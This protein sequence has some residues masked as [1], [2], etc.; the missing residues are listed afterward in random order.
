M[1]TV[2]SQDEV[3]VYRRLHHQ[4]FGFSEDELALRFTRCHRG[5]LL[6][7]DEW[8]RWPRWDETRW[9]PD[10]TREVFDLAR[11]VCRDAAKAAPKY[12]K[13]IRSARTVAAIVKLASADRVHARVTEDFDSDPWLLN[14]PGG[15]VDLR[16]G[17]SREH[18]RDDHITKI[19]KIAPGGDCPLWTE[20][21]KQWT[22]GGEELVNFLRRFVGYSLTGETREHVFC[23]LYGAGANG[24]SSFLNLLTWALGDY[25][26]TAPIETFTESKSDRHPTELAMLRGARL[27]AT[28]EMP[29]GR[30]WN[31]ERI[32]ALTGGGPIAARFMRRDYFE[33]IPQ[34][35][36]MIS[37]NHMPGP[38]NV[39]EAMKRRLLLVE[40]V[41]SFSWS[42]LVIRYA[43]YSTWFLVSRMLDQRSLSRGSTQPQGELEVPVPFCLLLLVFDGFPSFGAR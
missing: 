23:F 41:S 30:K 27:V 11:S 8:A 24:K 18:R 36:L 29:S 19:T 22:G 25:A 9:Q 17:E 28:D 3:E 2:V 4:K 35:K 40:S 21:L 15:T 43:M 31:E 34:F 13:S 37:G 7:V 33:Y 38:I 6:Y 32:K 10:R 1:N 14:T 20:S 39:G 26:T 16:S 12:A 5:D 42:S